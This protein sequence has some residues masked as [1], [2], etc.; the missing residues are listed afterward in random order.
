[1]NPPPGWI[2]G[3]GFMCGGSCQISE[4]TAS[5]IATHVVSDV[6]KV[7]KEIMMIGDVK[8]LESGSPEE[9]TAKI[10]AQA[11]DPMISSLEDVYLHC[12]GDDV[13]E[14]DLL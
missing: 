13:L 3:R 10:A 14:H 2:P 4:R 5:F 11:K 12:Y 7:A 9:L 1:M 8:L 6:E